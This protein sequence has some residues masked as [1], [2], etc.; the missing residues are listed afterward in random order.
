MSR[1]AA[2]FRESSYWPDVIQ[3]CDTLAEH[4]AELVTEEWPARADPKAKAAVIKLVHRV[5]Q[6]LLEEGRLAPLVDVKKLSGRELLAKLLD[7]IMEAPDARLMAYCVDL[8]METGVKLGAS[9]TSIA[10]EFK[11]TKSTVSHHCCHLKET[12]LKGRPAAGMK[13]VAAVE[14]YRKIRMGKSSRGPR[15][16]WQFATTFAKHYGSTSTTHSGPN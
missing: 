5:V 15:I 14:S 1:D 7:E 4:V 8:V 13:S 11:I 2:E 10:D 12:Y 16:D 9:M 3:G 6:R